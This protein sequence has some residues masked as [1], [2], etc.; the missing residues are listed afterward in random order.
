M[1]EQVVRSALTA[2][3]LKVIDEADPGQSK[4]V[5]VYRTQKRLPAGRNAKDKKRLR[6][7]KFGFDP[8]SQDVK[9]MSVEDAQKLQAEVDEKVKA[10]EKM[11][12]ENEF[13][14]TKF[15]ELINGQV[16]LEKKSKKKG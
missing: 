8:E 4:H 10:A 2:E 9:K 12:N 1:G 6:R 15:D 5:K 7:K 3:Q 13:D 11:F 16:G 14:R